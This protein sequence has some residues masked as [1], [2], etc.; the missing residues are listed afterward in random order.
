[1][2]GPVKP[3]IFATFPLTQAA[4]AHKLMESGEHVG[5]IVLTID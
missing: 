1:M 3:V 5:K 4:K 2:A